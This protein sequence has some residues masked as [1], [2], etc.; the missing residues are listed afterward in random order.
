MLNQHPI[1]V[2]VDGSAASTAAVRWAASEAARRHADLQLV[3]V[4]EVNEAYLWSMPELPDYLRELGRP[5]VTKAIELARRIAPDI[6]M[7]ERMLIGPAARML[8]MVSETAPM[9]VLGRSGRGALASHLVGSTTYRLA[10]HAHCPVVIVPASGASENDGPLE[11]NRIIVGLA[12]RPTEGRALDFA[13]DEAARHRVPLQLVRTWQA[14][15]A[16]DRA[17]RPDEQL[18]QM[19]ALLTKHLTSRRARIDAS[20]SVRA[21]LPAGVL[22]GLCGPGDLLVLGQHRHAPFLP[23]T[24]GKVVADCM[25][26]A[27]CPVAVVPEPMVPAERPERPRVNEAGL[28]AY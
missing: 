12:D 20:A 25:Q 27:P 4:C 18:E 6:E 16:S 22:S 1:A 7:H 10:A 13:I 3:H 19:N 15:H 23:P 9:M 11:T 26:Q 24:V 2:A 28:I 5:T 8:L 21:G 17:F 14:A